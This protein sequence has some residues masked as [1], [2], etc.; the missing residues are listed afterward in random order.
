MKNI[1]R[2]QHYFNARAVTATYT[3]V[4][5]RLSDQSDHKRIQP[6]TTEQCPDHA[7]VTHTELFVY[8]SYQNLVT[9]L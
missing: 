1:K 8:D 3:L 4:T 7:L 6:V 9:K 2:A 5:D